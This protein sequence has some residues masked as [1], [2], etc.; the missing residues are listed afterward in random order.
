MYKLTYKG[1]LVDGFDTEQ[2]VG[3]LAQLLNLKPKA[4]RLAF[5]SDRP[6]VIKM[7][8]SASE[9]ERWCAAFQEAGV[10]LDVAG[11][12]ASHAES[13]ANQIELDLEL[14][15]LDVEDDEPDERH[16]LIRKVLTPEPEPD[17][18]PET[19]SNQPLATRPVTEYAAA[20]EKSGTKALNGHSHQNTAAVT[21][22]G[23]KS[24]NGATASGA[25]NGHP[26]ENLSKENLNGTHQPNGMHQAKP[27]AGETASSG[28]APSIVA[29]A[30]PIDLSAPKPS[31]APAETA[32]HQ[33]SVAQ[34]DAL[35]AKQLL[36]GDFAEDEHVD[37][38]GSIAPTVDVTAA[39]VPR[40]KTT[41]TPGSLAANASTQHPPNAASASAPQSKPALE[42]RREAPP[43]APE[44]P[45]DTLYAPES[46]GAD[47]APDTDYDD[48]FDEEEERDEDRPYNR[49]DNRH[50]Q[51]DDE[52]EDELLEDVNFHKSHFLWGMLVILL[53]IIATAGT[54]LW[55]KRSTWE[56][57]AVAPVETKVMDAM[58]SATLFGLAHADLARLQGLSPAPNVFAHLPGP[59]P[60]FWSAVADG[61]IN[62]NQ[63]ATDVWMGAYGEQGRTKALWVL[64]GNFPVVAWRE[65]F[66]T[67]Y[68]I[69]SD[70]PEGVIF[71]TMDESTCQK[72]QV[73]SASV[74]E[75][76]IVLG[77]PELVAAYNGRLQAGAAAE[78]NLETWAKG[79]NTQ[80]I[81]A[82]LFHP[83][84]L[85]EGSAAMALGKLQLSAE[86]IQGIYLGLEPQKFPPALKF[87][88]FIESNNPQFIADAG[89][90]LTAATAAAKTTLAT[91]W[92][93][94]LPL[95]ER[96]KIA[97]DG[98]RVQASLYMD[99][100]APEQLR[101]WMAS[102]ANEALAAESPASVVA[103]ERLEENPA[104]FQNLESAEL[105]AFT[106]V[107]HLNETFIAQTSTGPFGIG[108][109]TVEKTDAGVE[110]NLDVNAFNLPNLGAEAEG[111]SL[112]IT[113]IVDHQDQ[114]LLSALGGCE[115]Q[116]PV[117]INSVYQANAMNNGEPIRFT[118]LQ[119]AKRIT[120]PAG[121]TLS[122]I[123][124]VK[125]V[126]SHQL[127]TE[128][129]RLDLKAPL[130]G[131][132]LDAHGVHLRFLSA[133]P[134]RLEFQV[135]GN[136]AA[137][138]Q[139]NALNAEGKVLATSN[140]VRGDTVMGGG[141]AV[142]IDY[143]GQVAAAE[144]VIAS[145]IQPRN[146][147]FSIA[148]LFP[149]AK[150][151]VAPKST[152]ARLNAANLPALEKDSPPTDVIYPFQSPRQTI[153][154][155]PALIAV[156]DLAI[157]A[158]HFS[159]SADIYT[160]NVHPLVGQLSAVHLAITEI[161]DSSGSLRSVNHQAPAA[162][163]Y[164]GGSWVDGK[165]EPDPNRPWLR[166]PIEM[167]NLPLE[168]NDVV[169]LWGKLVFLAT[170]DPVA[171]TVP[172]Q[173]G[174]QWNSSGGVLTL[175]RWEAGRLIFDVEGSFPGLMSV[176]AL[177][178][179]GAV[180]SQPAELR[181]HFGKASIELEVSQ[182][183]DSIEFSIARTQKPKEFPVEIRV[184]P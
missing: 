68:I 170:E 119:G 140:A 123:G 31:P 126:I 27:V 183:P 137:L 73:M 48:R 25:I 164:M 125:G 51:H 181:T 29:A 136:L 138:L 162:M 146:Y 169:A 62:L 144:V 108:V 1:Q 39:E 134:N 77:A 152:P 167:R 12:D 114:S 57:V 38:V 49:Y 47:E 13:I 82:V 109:R 61:G 2:V 93:E 177:D 155:G 153:A 149:P 180:V 75:N 3:N 54:I 131:K 141:K 41:D 124:A 120:L 122:T 69:D 101:L 179:T 171:V 118:G 104:S 160:R 147:Q 139:V 132:T 8:D 16:Y 17:L 142:T 159:L 22:T 112:L 99:E 20:V 96:L 70:S 79:Y 110:I 111:A 117:R 151:F 95:Y 83:G 42:A 18:A 59:L 148:R 7:L 165:F 107:K 133:G 34:I 5:L 10:Y 135:S 150:P 80:M 97:Q 14:H 9:V 66:A 90:K 76:Q 100:Q 89:G 30:N 84:Q 128:V 129:E 127:P 33:L 24:L 113:D 143:Q 21:G 116:Q 11:V 81:S 182:I 102:L 92:P 63:Q 46:K 91:D 98:N 40:V 32:V 103:E 88:A 172:F 106:S 64:H 72:S 43:V 166:G 26:K 65:W 87:N 71:S 156:N 37:E 36:E 115:M 154:A 74:S 15:Q 50:I 28:K 78:K 60:G 23:K 53:A 176:K 145:K 45:P 55:L 52:D 168:Q 161:E 19:F 163:E 4:V 130:A 58:A 178:E 85:P 67:H 44:P 121:M 86:S 6:S 35:A 184:I 157:S 175:H 56:P 173:F 174:M 105:P 94:T 158:Q